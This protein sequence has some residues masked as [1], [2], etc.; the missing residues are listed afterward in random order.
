MLVSIVIPCFNSET[1]Y[2]RTLQNDKAID[3][4]KATLE[5]VFKCSFGSKKEISQIK[6]NQNLTIDVKLVYVVLILCLS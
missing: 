3:D 4:I 1:Q 6:P 2:M 5:S